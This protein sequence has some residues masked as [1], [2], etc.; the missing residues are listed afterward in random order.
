MKIQQHFGHPTSARNDDLEEL[1]HY[2]LDFENSKCPGAVEVCC[3]H[4][5][6]LPLPSPEPTRKP[7]ERYVKPDDKR[8]TPCGRRHKNGIRESVK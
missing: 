8:K 5:G 4:P 7:I 6:S 1:P 3:R 2:E